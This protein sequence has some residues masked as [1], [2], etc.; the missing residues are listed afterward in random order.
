[1]ASG[2]SSSAK[3]KKHAAASSRKSPAAASVAALLEVP[4]ATTT[5]TTEAEPKPVD[6][7]APPST[8]PAK[9]RAGRKRRSEEPEPAPL[10]EA[11]VMS[12]VAVPAAESTPSR[13][14]RDGENGSKAKRAK[15]DKTVVTV[16]EAM[17]SEPVDLTSEGPTNAALLSPPP[18]G[19]AMRAGEN[20]STPSARRKSSPRIAAVE[21]HKQELGAQ[22]KG[23][24]IVKSPMVLFSGF[25]PATEFSMEVLAEMMQT[26]K[27]LGGHVYTGVDFDPLVG[28]THAIAPVSELSERRRCH[29][30]GVVARMSDL[31]C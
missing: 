3:K 10:P 18:S 2:D 31:A 17:S 14:T 8:P 12:D 22:S 11:A 27:D 20:A 24:S 21:E 25:K 23:V 29:T 7:E 15:A 28:V 30:A 4:T 19:A 13:G 16:V 5:S 26:V 6:T 1:M 9:S